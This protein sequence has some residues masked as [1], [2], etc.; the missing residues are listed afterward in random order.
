[1]CLGN[2]AGSPSDFV[3]FVFRFLPDLFSVLSMPFAMYFTCPQDGVLYGLVRG[4]KFCEMH[5][6][7]KTC[8]T[9][10]TFISSWKKVT[11]SLMFIVDSKRG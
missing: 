1:M 8:L 7:F 2:A 11:Q 3:V 4:L 10:F 5:R 6:A 9:I